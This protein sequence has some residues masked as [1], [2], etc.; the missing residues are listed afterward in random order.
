M[1]RLRTSLMLL[2]ATFR[3]AARRLSA[4]RRLAAGL[5]LGFT[6]AVSAASSVPAFATGALQRMLQIE[7]AGVLDKRMPAAVHLAHFEDP[8]HPTTAAQYQAADKIA[9]VDGPKLIGLPIEPFVRYGSLEL[10]NARPVDKKVMRD[11]ID[12]WMAL[13][14]MSDLQAHIK[15]VDGR[16]PTVGK[17]GGFYEVIVEEDALDK[18]DITVGAEMQVPVNRTTTS[19][20][21]QVRVVGAFR[22]SDPSEL[23]WFMSGPFEQ[24]LFVSEETYRTSL[25][26]EPRATAGQYSWYYGIKNEDVKM[27]DVYR[28]LSDQYELEARVAQALAN[29]EF[30]E[31]PFTLLQ[32]YLVKAGQLQFMLLLLAV[33]PLA[34]VAY[35]LVVT[36]GLMVDG[37]R[38]EISVLRSR[39]AS[40]WQ[41]LSVY[42]LEGVLMG[43]LSLVGGY[44]LGVLLARAMG[45][46]SGFLQFVDRKQPE[47]L[48]SPDFWTYGLGAAVLALV[49][50]VLPVIPAARQSIIS[51]KTE[52]ARKLQRP[53]WAR[54]GL[55]FLCVGAA[56]YAYY[57]LQQK[58]AAALAALAKQTG[59]AAA[60]RPDLVLMQPLDI[61]APALFVAGCGLVLLRVVPLVA[62]LAAKVAERPAGAPVYLT[63]TQLSRAASGYTPVIL[64]LTLTVGMGLYSANAARTLEQNTADRVRYA[65][66]ADLELEEVWEYIQESP[67]GPITDT[68]APPWN[69]HYNLPGVVHPARVRREPVTIMVSGRQQGKGRLMA[70]DSADFGKV[71]WFRP[72]LAPAHFYEYLNL[73]AQDEEAVLVTPTFM[74]RHKLKP[75]DRISLIA[76]N[77]QDVSLVIYGAV[78]YWPSLYPQENEFF[79][80]NLD[81]VE[82][83]LGLARYSVWFKLEEGAKVQ[84]IIDALKQESIS[85]LRA[86]DNRKVLINA[87]RDPQLNGLLGGLTSGFLLSAA[88][89][90]LGFWLYAALSLRSRVLQFGVL[91]AMGLSVRQ[92][93]GAVA[94]EQVL[95]VGLGVAAGTGLGFAASELFVPFLQQGTDAASRT[96]PFV[97]VSDP[98]DRIRLYAVLLFML[99]AGLSGL[100]AVLSRMRVHEAIKLGE[101]H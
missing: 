25:V 36:S 54:W 98:A 94:M 53:F 57:T 3:I 16:W 31:G 83:G 99:I 46:S 66:G 32:R 47:L 56:G 41:V 86:Q 67:D 65:T 55:D 82:Q 64:L 91:R 77:G 28:L 33:P 61:L 49:A 59:S 13:S 80:A 90:M 30:F 101:D 12:R 27:T 34:V 95:S 76:E 35:F 72:D 100:M 2:L 84:T 50:Y 97:I 73:L 8:K 1:K 39:G 81:Y 58:H 63:L 48:L 60:A 93:L 11:D 4:N 51:Y 6:V 26:M 71:A 22:R 37:Q 89:T 87:R 70:I 43:G 7:L 52:S 15:I 17:V 18:Q 44:P 42:V 75:G 45:A 21:V 29:T 74:A 62:L 96:P 85:T 24:Q 88:I 69:V 19:P 9:T 38:Q 40:L 10:T 5:L 92:L 68:L 78:Q 79:I 23:Y 14:F 20:L